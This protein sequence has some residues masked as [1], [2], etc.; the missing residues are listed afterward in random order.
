H[1]GD[2]PDI[3]TL[4]NAHKNGINI[5]HLGRQFSPQDFTEFDMLLAMDKS[6]LYNIKKHDMSGVYEAKIKLMRAFDA[7]GH[8]EDVPDPY[9]GG[10]SGFQEVFEILDRST[11]ALLDFI[12]AEKLPGFKG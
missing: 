9:F 1:I 4:K 8:M 3:R 12:E 6:N 2:P 11:H 10:E 5:I 7:H